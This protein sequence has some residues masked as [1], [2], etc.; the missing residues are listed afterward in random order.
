MVFSG[1][2]GG[3]HSGLQGSLQQVVLRFDFVARTSREDINY[4]I[5]VLLGNDVS[6]EW[7]VTSVR[8][9]CHGDLKPRDKAC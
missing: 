9:I 5:L 8:H 6:S 4:Q 1:F 7:K 3:F 2:H